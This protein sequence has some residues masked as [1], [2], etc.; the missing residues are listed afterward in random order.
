MREVKNN[1]KY[2]ES[3]EFKEL[4]LY[5]GND[6]G[7]VYDKKKTWFKLWSPLAENIILHLYKE[8][9][10]CKSESF[11]MK[12]GK[13][14]VWEYQM[15]GNCHGI[16]YDFTV[17]I[18]GISYQTADPYAKA[19]NCNGFRSM[20]VDLER[21]NPQGWKEDK[22]P[23]KTEEQIIYEIHIKD[24][25]YDLAS[26]VPEK[27]RGKYKA[28]TI[29]NTTLLGQGK[30][31]T[32]LSYLK[33]LGVTHIQ[34]MPVFDFNTVNEAG[35]IEE[36]NWGYDPLNYNVPEGS[37]AT[38]PFHGE[39]RIRE[40][41][42]LIMTVHNY[43]MRVI[44][45]VVYNHTH[46]IDSWFSKTV[47]GYFYRQF[48][49]GTYSNGSACGNDFASEREMC[50]KYILE[51]VLYWVSEYHIDGFRF[52]L[53]GL[54]D[55]ELLNTIQ[56]EMDKR[57]GKGEI[58]LYGEPWNAGISPMAEGYQPCLKENVHLLDKQ[59]GIFCDKTRDAI[60]GNVF[61]DEKPGFVNGGENYGKDILKAVHAWSEIE[62]KE[63]DFRVKAPSQI[64]SY[65]SAHDNLTLWDKLIATLKPN[66]DFERRYEEVVRANK[67]AA[68]VYFTCQGRIFFLAGEEGARTKL[69]DGNSYA[70]GAKLNRIDWK[71]IYE[72]EDILSYYQGLIAFRKRMPGL[73]DKS[74]YA[75]KRIF[76]EKVIMENLVQFYVDNREDKKEIEDKKE[77]ESIKNREIEENNLWDTLA[78]W[79]NSTRKEQKLELPEGIWEILVDGDSSFLWKNP[80][81]VQG[82]QK[83]SPVSVK[84]FGKGKRKE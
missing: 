27:Y 20:V 50:R 4:Y 45:D 39:V 36:Y 13:Q 19:C 2:Y 71:R 47:P 58:L 38:D 63:K 3:K 82:I 51:S 77:T 56:Q 11:P 23:K 65:I 21:T 75:S 24:F 84:I 70:S 15:L 43:G 34:L 25:S 9:D 81:S 80:Q 41:K 55:V 83:I 10:S 12:K 57:F 17:I 79:Y 6:L 5:D 1:Q 61:K 40:L 16:Y 53:M 76:G 29:G 22:A 59:I 66:A 54:L 32:C 31:P 7:A 26:D 44:M 46:N 78:I 73:F 62:G 72:Y 69:G 35:S 8:G 18:D 68:A 64:I 49:D 42:E 30:K 60:K 14:G 48:P 67:M 28:F 37:Y 52:D 33:N 74:E